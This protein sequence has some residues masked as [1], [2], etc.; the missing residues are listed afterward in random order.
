[1]RKHYT[2]DDCNENNEINITPFID[3][4]LVLL[5]IFMVTTSVSTTHMN[6]RL[7][8]LSQKMPPVTAPP[9]SITINNAENSLLVDGHKVLLSELPD[10]LS[11]LVPDTEATIFVSADRTTAYARIMEVL[12]ILQQLGYTSISLMANSK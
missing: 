6:I 1:M 7:P 2:S 11:D 10:T 12:D 5:V 8:E 4:L 3:I 9:T